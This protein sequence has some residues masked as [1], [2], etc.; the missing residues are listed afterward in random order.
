MV[1]LLGATVCQWCG[2]GL[3]GNND[4]A[5]KTNK[6]TNKKTK[7]QKECRKKQEKEMNY[8]NKGRPKLQQ[9]T[10]SGNKLEE[11]NNKSFGDM[12][13]TKEEKNF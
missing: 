1:S 4:H 12:M 10:V 3:V 9:T 8:I 5:R 13:Q 2:L 6:Q 7:K 11:K